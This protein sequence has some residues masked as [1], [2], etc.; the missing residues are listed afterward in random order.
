MSGP[1]ERVSAFREPDAGGPAYLADPNFA[2]WG[3]L[4]HCTPTAVVVGTD[5]SAWIKAGFGYDF[6][7]GFHPN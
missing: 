4:G 2:F 3:K 6:V 7:A 1:G 5:H